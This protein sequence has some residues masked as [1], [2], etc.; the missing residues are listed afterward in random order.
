MKNLLHIKYTS[1]QYALNFIW[2]LFTTLFLV[3]AIYYQWHQYALQK[4]L[5]LK[6]IANFAGFKIDLLFDKLLD[7]ANALPLYGPQLADC[8]QSL[9]P[10]FKRIVFNT[11]Q[12]VGVD[13]RAKNNKLIC[14]T[15]ESKYQ[16][17]SSSAQSPAL[18]GPLNNANNSKTFLLQKQVG[19]YYFGVY[20]PE[21]VLTNALK[22]TSS[23]IQF[24]ALY[25]RL[26][27]KIILQVG[28]SPLSE[29]I[30]L[31]GE[32]FVK[33]LLEKLDNYNLIIAAQTKQFNKDFF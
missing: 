5:Q 14:S 23:D 18:I 15:M 29:K 28:E 11:P 20:I 26:E 4:Q 2:I 24:I 25:N 30:S 9:R 19:Q 21:K 33:V 3:F 22:S 10:L 13:I 7:N 27:K 31:L 17:P 32:G 8:N 16:L 12:I 6:S 1:A